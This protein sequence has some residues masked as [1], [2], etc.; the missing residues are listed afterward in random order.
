MVED[1]KGTIAAAVLGKEL[2][3]KPLSRRFIRLS[4]RCLIRN[5]QNGYFLTRDKNRFHLASLLSKKVD[6]SQEWLVRERAGV[7]STSC[8]SSGAKSMFAAWSG[9]KYCFDL[10]LADSNDANTS[11]WV[12]TQSGQ[13]MHRATGLYLTAAQDRSCDMIRRGTYEVTLEKPDGSIQ[14]QWQLISVLD[15]SKP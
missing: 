7:I 2:N 5:P 13:I 12:F 10:G 6:P 1:S 11:Q 9:T 3:V 14:Q 8:G 4:R 15:D